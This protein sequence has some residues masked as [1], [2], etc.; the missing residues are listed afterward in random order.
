MNLLKKIKH[1]KLIVDCDYDLD[2]IVRKY[3]KTGDEIE[4]YSNG[5]LDKEN[6]QIK[7]SFICV[8][9]LGTVGVSKAEYDAN[10]NDSR[11]SIYN[12]GS[13]IS[14]AFTDFESS[15]I[16]KE[17]YFAEDGFSEFHYFTELNYIDFLNEFD[18]QAFDSFFENVLLKWCYESFFSIEKVIANSPKIKGKMVL[19]DILK[20]ILRSNDFLEDFKSGTKSNLI[21]KEI[22]KYLIIYNSILLKNIKS[23]FRI[24]FPSIIKNIPDEIKKVRENRVLEDVLLACGEM[25][26]DKM[27]YEDADENSRTKQILR[28]LSRSYRTSDQSQVGKSATGIKPG[29]LDGL[30]IDKKNNE[31]YIEALNLD[32]LDRKSITTH[33]NKLEKNYDNKGLEVKFVIVYCNLEENKFFNFSEKYKD[34]LNTDLTFNYKLVEE[35]EEVLTSINHTNRR[36]FKTSHLRENKK[37]YL[38][39]ILLKLPLGKNNID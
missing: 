37:V 8:E 4:D 3:G 18:F 30:I 15:E 20:K 11:Y 35:G 27:Y 39:H 26:E 24:I 29:S 7:R 12:Y 31:Y 1:K 28:L 21:Q 32:C 13:E 36:I 33:V 5:V 34:Y 9:N 14:Y 6:I 25:Q 16:S 19:I 22:C 2:E 23:R 10:V 38:Y 17:E